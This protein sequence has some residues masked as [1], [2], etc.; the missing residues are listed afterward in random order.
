MEEI[1]E[2]DS[3]KDIIN[4]KCDKF[5][6]RT[7]FLEKDGIHKEFQKITYAKLKEDVNAMG[8]VMLKNLD[9]KDKKVAVIGENSYKWFVTYMAVTCGVGT[10]VP[11]DKELPQNEILN[12]L[13]RSESS[14]IVYSSRRKDLVEGIKEQ[15]PKDM[16]FI[17]MGKQETDG[18]SFSYN[19]LIAQG[20]ELVG[21]GVTEYI[22]TKID[23]EEF[24]ILLFTSGT[25]A[26]A[27]GA[28][29][30]HKNICANTVACITLL[31]GM[32]DYTTL[33]VLPM[34][35][36]YEFS[37]TFIYCL[38]TGG[39]VGICEG[40]KYVSKNIQE[41]KPDC[42]FV[43][44]ALIEK[45]YQKI[46]KG[47]KDS[48][49]EVLINTMKGI[50]TGLSKIGINIKRKVFKEIYTKLGGNLKYIFCGA[51]PIDRDIVKKLEGLGLVF[52]QGYGLTETSPLV[53]VTP[54]N[55]RVAGS[56]GKAVNGVEIRIDLS[57]NEDENSNVGE[58]M[59]KGENVFMG[60]YKMQEETK[61]SLKKGW[62]YT[63]DLGYFDIRGN[64]IISGRNKNV[65]VTSN[66]KNIFPEEIENMINRIPMVSESMVYGML[67]DKNKQDLIVAAKVT[68]NEEYIEEV[69]LSNRPKDKEI[70]DIIWAEIKK[71]NKSMVPYKAVKKLEVKK[72]DFIKTTT[73]KIKRFEELKKDKMNIDK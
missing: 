57:G 43:V 1:K 5:A 33:S 63:G 18:I 20:M 17:E 24:R 38:T 27:K 73:M 68:L 32:G 28:M 26:A 21:T 71:I 15:L 53:S 3:L 47:I 62:F 14:A 42:L 36:T 4:I 45:V 40:L 19:K 59:V 10:I 50:T 31:P 23:R 34:H 54:E 67:D 60:Y 52:M 8:T 6:S 61:K 2:M 64:L 35:H 12:L 30:N 51:A 70:Y 25:T 46:E 49:K 29:L 41:V 65:I 39:T 56:V 66:G 11:L 58:I 48:G 7:A 37:L 69:Y 72:D 16:L 44:P 55:D 9:L 13:K 22:D